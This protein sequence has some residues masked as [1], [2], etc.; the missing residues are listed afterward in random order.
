[1]YSFVVEQ[2]RFRRRSLSPIA[3]ARAAGNNTV[4]YVLRHRRARVIHYWY[5]QFRC[6]ITVMSLV[7]TGY[8]G[9]Q[10][11]VGTAL[12]RALTTLSSV[13]ARRRRG[14]RFLVEGGLST[15]PVELSSTCR[16]K[17]VLNS[18]HRIFKITRLHECVRCTKT[19]ND[20]LFCVCDYPATVVSAPISSAFSWE[21]VDFL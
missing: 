16:T 2:R 9:H 6:C 4:Y 21:T 20:V 7:D 8:R 19:V 18:R 17:I 3:H 1:L 10:H 5:V 11:R 13:H 15:R 12:S 14:G